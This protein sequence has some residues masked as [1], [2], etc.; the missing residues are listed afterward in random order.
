MLMN[1]GFFAC[2]IPLVVLG[3]FIAFGFVTDMEMPRRRE[4]SLPLLIISI[5]T[6]IGSYLMGARLAGTPIGNMILGEGLLLFIAGGVSLFWKISLHAIGAGGLL[7]YVVVTGIMMH[8]D[9]SL[10]AAWAFIVSGLA[11]WARLY[12]D[13]H[14]PGQM[15]SGFI[16]GFAVMFVVL[17][18]LMLA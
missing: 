16:L 12:E 18:V 11:A 17:R 3:V 15:L 13:A 8:I 9:F 2:F 7:A 4:R 1:V 5:T 10:A 14:T 6:C